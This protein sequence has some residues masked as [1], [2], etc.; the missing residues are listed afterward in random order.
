[1]TMRMMIVVSSNQTTLFLSLLLLI[2]EWLQVAIVVRKAK[3][4]IAIGQQN[5]IGMR[6]T[7]HVLALLSSLPR[8]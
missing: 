5:D 4:R 7:V 1:M 8:M 2:V 6:S 3:Q